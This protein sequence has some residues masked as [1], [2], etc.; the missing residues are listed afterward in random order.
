[1]NIDELINCSIIEGHISLLSSAFH[2]SADVSSGGRIRAL[3]S[4]DLAKLSSIEV[5]TD[6]LE[7]QTGDASETDLAFLGRLRVILG[8][9]L[10]T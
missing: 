10:I 4:L 1:M 3:D 8:R 9:R 2:N 7:V 5:I 6:Y